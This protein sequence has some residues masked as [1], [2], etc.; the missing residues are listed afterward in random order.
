MILRITGTEEKTM[1]SFKNDYSEGAHPEVLK[2]LLETNMEQTEG[3][4]LDPYFAG[5]TAYKITHPK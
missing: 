1:H 5:N 2:L 3:Y 4:G